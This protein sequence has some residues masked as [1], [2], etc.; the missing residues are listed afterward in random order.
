PG[1][2]AWQSEHIL[3]CSDDHIITHTHTLSPKHTLSLSLSQT[4]THT[5]THTHTRTQQH[6]REEQGFP[7]N[8][9]HFCSGCWWSLIVLSVGYHS[10]ARGQHELHMSPYR[11]KL[12]DRQTDRKAHTQLHTHPHF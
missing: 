3:I 9:G 11:Y 1:S 8:R 2:M 4:H 10:K 12:P 5:H 7:R 6:K